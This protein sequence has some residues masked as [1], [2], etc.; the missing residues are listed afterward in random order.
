[1]TGEEAVV[2]RGI[3]LGRPVVM[4]TVLLAA[5]LSVASHVLAAAETPRGSGAAPKDDRP[6][7][8]VFGASY[9]KNWVVDDLDG[10]RVVNKGIGGDDTSGMLARLD[11]DVVALRP[12]AVLIWGFINDIFRSPR[13]QIIATSERTRSNIL[14]MLDRVRKAGIRPILA[15]EV[16]ITSPVGLQESLG[17]WLGA[18]RGKEGYHSY[19]NRHVREL[20]VWLRAVAAE[21]RISL[22]DFEVV[23]GDSDGER[24]RE[25]STDDGSHLS[26]AAY[27]ALTTYASGK[28]RSA[29]GR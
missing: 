28:I 2:Q 1:M 27:T 10:S 15:T 14:G 7:I 13:D 3:R 16:T 11:R 21:Q 8:V 20:N 12:A 25:Y 5:A 24:R 23:L 26:A 9:A 4:G 6:V 29:A 19:V 18:L 22:L 17:R